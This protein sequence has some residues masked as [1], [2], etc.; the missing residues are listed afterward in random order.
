MPDLCVLITGTRYATPA[1]WRDAVHGVLALHLAQIGD[2]T[3]HLVHGGARGI[4][5]IAAQWEQE[6][7]GRWN[8]SY[9][10]FH[11]DWDAHGRAA[12]PI[13]NAL[14]RDRLLDLQRMGFDVA[15]CAFTDDITQSRGTASMCRLASAAG[16]PVTVYGRDG[17]GRAFGGGQ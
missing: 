8:I 12:G 5:T 6:R 11:A 1:D 15:V 9:E 4:D 2:G 17:T 3:L 13:R 16:L 14:M 10:V 7:R